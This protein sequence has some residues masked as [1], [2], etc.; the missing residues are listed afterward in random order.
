M[1]E[2]KSQIQ[3]SDEFG[4]FGVMEEHKHGGRRSYA[5]PVTFA[6]A[7]LM[8][9]LV[10]GVSPASAA[11]LIDITNITDTL[12][13]IGNTLFGGILALVVGAWP[14]MIV[15]GIMMFV[16]KFLDKILDMFH[17]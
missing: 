8:V 5:R 17:F 7:V 10:F 11:S 14:V 4:S 16:N 13:A 15:V 9:L 1:V 6:G 12:T 3:A 2:A